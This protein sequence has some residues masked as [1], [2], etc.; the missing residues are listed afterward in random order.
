MT[1]YKPRITRRAL[2]E[3][4]LTL[5]PAY[6]TYVESSF[7]PFQFRFKAVIALGAY[8]VVQFIERL[9]L[10]ALAPEHAFYPHAAFRAA[11]HVECHRL[12]AV[13]AFLG[14]AFADRGACALERAFQ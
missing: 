6:R 2:S 10:W 5:E 4:C 12:A 13:R 3:I 14:W 8:L 11:L 1:L 9:A 7:S